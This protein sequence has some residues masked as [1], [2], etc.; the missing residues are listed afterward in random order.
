NFYKE[1]KTNIYMLDNSETYQLALTKD[2]LETRTAE[3]RAHGLTLMQILFN[4]SPDSY[5]INSSY[6]KLIELS[7][8]RSLKIFYHSLEEK[9]KFFS[10]IIAENITQKIIIEPKD[11]K[12]TPY[13][14]GFTINASGKIVIT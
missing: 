10:R 1:S 14:N 9:E 2:V 5:Q 11:I 4:L 12:A 8:D 6:T 7:G 3:A 13:K